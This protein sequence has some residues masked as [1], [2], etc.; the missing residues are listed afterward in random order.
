ME[1]EEKVLISERVSEDNKLQ[2]L[3]EFCDYL[4]DVGHKRN[5]KKK[6]RVF[7]YFLQ[8]YLEKLG[9]KNI[10]LT[11]SGDDGGIDLIA[12]LYLDV[13]IKDVEII[14]RYY[15]SAKQFT[16]NEDIQPRKMQPSQIRDLRGAIE[17]GKGI[18]ITTGKVTDNAKRNA[19]YS[20]YV[21]KTD[22]ISNVPKNIPIYV[23]DY[24]PLI[25]SFIDLELEFV[26]VKEIDDK[27]VTI[28]LERN[29]LKKD[30]YWVVRW[31]CL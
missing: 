14:D 4:N 20:K 1:R 29:K 24:K 3:I 28:S 18:F 12:D 17:T 10:I 7:E 27:N 8:Y 5:I 31:V 26:K 21:L 9:F 6:G 23:I 2:F 15:I 16:P 11:P 13:F 19:L 25:D 30:S 22:S